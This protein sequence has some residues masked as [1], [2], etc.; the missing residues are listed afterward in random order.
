[1]TKEEAQKKLQAIKAYIL[2]PG[3]PHVGQAWSVEPIREA[4][5]M[6]IEALEQSQ[7]IPCSVKLPER[8]IN[9]LVTRD[10]DGRKDFQ[11]SRTYVETAVCYGEDEDAD[12]VSFSDEYKTTPESHR[13][14]AWMPL[15]E[16]YLVKEVND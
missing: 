14:I 13:V 7:W 8:G 1:M 6:A 16:P 12:W 10:Y 15:P 11:R 5:D 4:F 3:N 9:V 2:P